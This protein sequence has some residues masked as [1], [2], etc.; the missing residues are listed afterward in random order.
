MDVERAR[1]LARLQQWGEAT[2]LAR[3]TLARG[4]VR[5]YRELMARSAAVMHDSAK[6]R[7]E[8]AQANVWRARAIASLLQDAGSHVGDRALS[9]ERLR[10]R[11]RDGCGA[12]RR[13]LRTALRRRAANA[14]RIRRTARG[15]LRADRG[16]RR[17]DACTAQLRGQARRCGSRRC[18]RRLG[19]RALRANAQRADRGDARRCFGR[20]DR[21]G[22]ERGACAPSRR[23]RASV[24]A[25]AAR[26]AAG[27]CRRSSAACRVTIRVSRSFEK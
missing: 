7:G 1:H 14:G 18:A 23:A 24:T 26:G 9:C 5:G 22:L 25:T 17:C 8:I 13:A 19:A 21:T 15:C 10:R 12:C 6:T 2:L 27:D 20:D 11:V 4:E 16:A 3:S